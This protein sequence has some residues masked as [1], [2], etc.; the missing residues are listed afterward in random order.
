MSD[1]QFR[2]EALARFAEIPPPSRTVAGF[3]SADTLA[4]NRLRAA[5]DARI[6]HRER[7]LRLAMGDPKATEMLQRWLSDRMADTPGSHLPMR[8]LEMAGE[9][10][11]GGNLLTKADRI[12]KYLDG[13]RDA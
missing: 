1:A 5:G 2:R 13:E 8:A 6:A 11:G 4:F 9:F 12:L 7:L 3:P 10:V